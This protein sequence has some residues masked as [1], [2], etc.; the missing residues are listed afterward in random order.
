MV[1]LGNRIKDQRKKA[2]MSQEKLAEMVGVSRQAVTKWEADLSAPTTA[3]LFVLAEIL[4]TKVDVLMDNE[5]DESIRS[6]A[7]ET[8]Y[9]YK[10]EAEKKASELRRMRKENSRLAQIIAICHIGLMVLG[11]IVA[12]GFGEPSVLLDRLSHYIPLLIAAAISITSALMGK[13]RLSIVTFAANGL[14][15]LLGICLGNGYTGSRYGMS[16]FGWAVWAGVFLVSLAA[17][18]MW[19]ISVSKKGKQNQKKT[20]LLSGI[21][22]TV[23]VIMATI[24]ITSVPKYVQPMYE[25]ASYEALLSEFSDE[26]K[27]RLPRE[28]DLPSEAES[29]L[30][31]L[32]SRSSNKKTGY[33][34]S[35]EPKAGI[36]DIYTITGRL[37]SSHDD[38]SMGLQPD[39]VYKGTGIHVNRYD[40]KFQFGD[41][42]YLIEFNPLSDQCAEEAVSLAKAMIDLT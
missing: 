13:R 30:V 9:R 19:E 25:V 3:N 8:Y 22:L 20:W 16:Y 39:L 40:V 31:N 33:F 32:K 26:P 5:G 41:C 7:G 24:I 23:M 6:S 2:G 21:V 12:G 1:S 29:C 4:G 27:F 17:G 36:F 14:G 34:I 35:L 37:A 15:S 11:L 10:M 42:Q 28:E 18:L 38:K